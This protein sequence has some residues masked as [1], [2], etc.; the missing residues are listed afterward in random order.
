MFSQADSAGGRPPVLAAVV[1]PASPP[2]R[3]TRF[4]GAG[5]SREMWYLASK[6]DGMD[7]NATYAGLAVQSMAG[8]AVGAAVPGSGVPDCS[9]VHAA[10][11]SARAATM[12]AAGSRAPRRRHPDRRPGNW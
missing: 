7:P 5:S 1:G 3:P 9:S 10:I 6:V 8:A 12:A 2:I 4:N 11:V